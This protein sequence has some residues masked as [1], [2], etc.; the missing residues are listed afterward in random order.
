MRDR[1]LKVEYIAIDKL[2]GW[3]KNP[4]NNNEAAERLSGLIEEHGFINPIIATPDGTIR[5]G[6]TRA[7][8]AQLKGIKKVP[9]IFVEFESEAKAEAFSIADNRSGEWAEWD[10][11]ALA[12]ILLELD[13]GEF[14]IDITGFNMDE[15]E[16][17]IKEYGEQDIKEE[18][19][20]NPEE[21]AEKIETPMSQV[22][23]IWLLGNHRVICGDSTKSE[24]YALLFGDEQADIVFT[25]PPYNVNYEGQKGMKI[26]NDNQGDEQFYN[27]LNDA[28]TQMCVYTKA[29]CPIYICHADSEGLNF[30]KAAKTSGW[31]ITQTLIWVKNALVMGRQDYQWQHEP[32]LYGWKPGAAHRWFGFRDKTTVID[33]DID[34]ESL[35]KAELL[36][37]VKK[38]LAV[39]PTT[40]IREDKPRENDL[41]P[42]MK[43]LP[44]IRNCLENSSRQTNIVM[45]PFLGSGSTLIASEQL[46]RVC[47]GMELDPIYTDVIVKR[48]IKFKGS[49]QGVRLLRAGEE[50]HISDCEV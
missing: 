47:Y 25:D 50:K 49:D 36:G 30:R 31:N 42:T 7:K 24:T 8:A 35:K 38:L 37:L 34:I 11:R 48:Y 40:I 6:H 15:I 46:D 10:Y 9:V 3:D 5:A 12:Q 17:L 44:L 13:T 22:G 16:D 29:G 23:D 19:D 4:R 20:F 1:Q 27:F 14:K 43:P 33:D 32:I 28:F 45:D 41:H 2:K 39:V 21:E 18:E 26:I